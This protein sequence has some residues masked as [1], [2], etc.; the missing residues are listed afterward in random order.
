MHLMPLRLV[1]L[2]MVLLGGRAGAT[3]SPLLMPEGTSEFAIG[4][5]LRHGEED[6]GSGRRTT[7][8][9]PYLQA[10]W[11]NGVFLDGLWLGRQL[12][13]VPH[14]RYGPLLTVAREPLPRADGDRR[15]MP[16]FGAFLSYNL[17]HNLN[18]SVHGYRMAGPR[19]DAMADVRVMSYNSVAP[20]HAFAIEAGLRLADRRHL[21]AQF[22]VGPEA[23]SGIKDAYVGARWHWELTPKYTAV[24]GLEYKRLCGDAASAPASARRSSLASHLLLI[25]RY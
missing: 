14:L 19:G 9:Q 4:A 2:A 25:Y 10:Q 7:W 11:S 5:A 17:L 1:L 21:Q 22:G 16:V 24:A 20:H 6:E 8:L 23:S 3:E 18:F 13:G 12:S 15:L